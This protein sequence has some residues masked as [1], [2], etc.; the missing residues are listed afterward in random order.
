MET[1]NFRGVN[2]K[3]ENIIKISS[4]DKK[5]SIYC[6]ADTPLGLMHDFLLL[7]KGNIVERMS[8]AQNEEQ[9]VTDKLKEKET[10]EV[11]E[12]EVQE[13]TE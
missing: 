2:M 7:L 13:I 5:I 11:T 9:A 8:A 12:P 1:H 3:Q 10:E 4:E 6:D